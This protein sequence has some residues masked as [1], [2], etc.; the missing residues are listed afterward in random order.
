M[1]PLS[2]PLQSFLDLEFGLRFL[3]PK[4]NRVAT[5]EIVMSPLS[6]TLRSFLNLG[7]G[8]NILEQNQSQLVAAEVVASPIAISNWNEGN[9]RNF[10]AWIGPI[11]P[12]EL[13]VALVKL[14]NENSIFH[15]VPLPDVQPFNEP[16]PLLS[17]EN[18]INGE[19][20]LAAISLFNRDGWL[21][22]S[23]NPSHLLAN[24][25]ASCACPAC[26]MLITEAPVGYQ[27]GAA[28][29][30]PISFDKTFKLHSNPF[31]NHTIY[32]DFDGYFIASSQWENGGA[33]S[34]SLTTV[35]ANLPT[36]IK[37][38]SRKYGNGLQKTSLPLMLMSPPKNPIQK[39]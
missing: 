25:S 26:A 19:F 35:E 36:P 27:D 18:G 32:L 29:I 31:A 20:E 12:L 22:E 34:F 21:G 14:S 30:P 28:S 17:E 7:F 24:S 9:F 10:L 3:W 11:F 6:T 13:T 23:S 4:E 15:L 5:S 1:D 39:I 37:K 2:D 33:S 38:K 8:Q 16:S